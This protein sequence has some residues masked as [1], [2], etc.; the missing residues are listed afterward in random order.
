LLKKA[1]AWPLGLPE[2]M[3]QKAVRQQVGISPNLS[4][5]EIQ[6]LRALNKSYPGHSQ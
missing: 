2:F 4:M 3:P 1:V 6:K 5:D